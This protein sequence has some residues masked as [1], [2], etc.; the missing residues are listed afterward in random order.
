MNNEQFEVSYMK[1]ISLSIEAGTSEK[2]MDLTEK[3]FDLNFIFGVGADGITLFE[4]ALF[5]KCTG[6][7]IIV[8]I[9]PHQIN[10]MLGHL[11]QAVQN[12]LPMKTPCFL[13]ACIVSV[14]TPDQ[15]EIVRAIA[16]GVVSGGCDCG[17]GC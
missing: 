9:I 10:D 7:E 17:C 15:R 14:D 3:P 2:N 8:E 13:K 12:L 11:K 6:D 16:D 1:K 5:G 4:K